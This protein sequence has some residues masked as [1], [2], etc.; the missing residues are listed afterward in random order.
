M[1]GKRGGGGWIDG[2]DRSGGAAACVF[3]Q[4]P[5]LEGRARGKMD[6]LIVV[7]GLVWSAGLVYSGLG[8]ETGRGRLTCTY[9]K[10]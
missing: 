6:D 1:E 9:A 2:W 10:A 4:P 8:L 7:A 3:H 5:P